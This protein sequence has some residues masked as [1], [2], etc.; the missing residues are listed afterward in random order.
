MSFR[1]QVKVLR[2]SP[3]IYGDDGRYTRGTSSEINIMA[4]IQPLGSQER[5][6]VVGPEGGRN[7]AYV[8]AYTDVYLRPQRASET[9]TDGQDADIIEWQGRRFAVIQCD[10]YQSGVISHYRAYAKEVLADDA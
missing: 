4:S 1:K 9:G 10:A 6:T 7:V 2:Q 8:K 3:G 5:Y